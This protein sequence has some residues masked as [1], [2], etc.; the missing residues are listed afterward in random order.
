MNVTN[1]VLCASLAISDQFISNARSWNNCMYGLRCAAGHD[2][3]DDDDD[4]DDEDISPGKW[5]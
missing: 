1:L 2:D 3:D 4:D 5:Y